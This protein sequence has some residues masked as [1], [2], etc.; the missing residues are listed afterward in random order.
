MLDEKEHLAQPWKIIHRNCNISQPI[1]FI[2]D[3]SLSIPLT[4]IMHC[5]LNTVFRIDTAV[6]DSSAT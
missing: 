2:S 4:F 1:N 3:K 6:S 5:V